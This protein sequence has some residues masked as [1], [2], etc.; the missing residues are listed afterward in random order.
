[1]KL[2]NDL[3]PK[4]TKT[5]G[6]K[7]KLGDNDQMWGSE[8]LAALY[9]QHPYLGSYETHLQVEG[10]DENLGYLYGHFIVKNPG[11]T[12]PTQASS[13]H[14]GQ[15]QKEV[16]PGAPEVRIPVVVNSGDLSALDVFISPSNAFMPL[17][18]DRLAAS[19]FQE[20]NFVPV[21][22]SQASPHPSAAV[23][24]N[25]VPNNGLGGV[26]DHSATVKRASVIEKVASYMSKEARAAIVSDLEEVS[27][28]RYALARNKNFANAM[29]KFASTPKFVAS[30]VDVDSVDAAVVEKVAGGYKL[31]V[32]S[33]S[34]FEPVS[35]TVPNNAS[36]S[37]PWSTRAD[38]VKLGAALLSTDNNPAREVSTTEGRLTEVTESGV[39]A[40]MEKTGRATRGVVLTN[41]Q[42]LEGRP[43]DLKLAITPEGASLQDK[44]AGVRCGDIDVSRIEGKPPKGDGVFLLKSGAVTEPLTINNTINYPDRKEYTYTS[45]MG[46]SGVLKTASVA[47]P[48]NV[49]GADYLI[50]E[51]IKF[52]P[53]KYSN[54]V[55]GDV[56]SVEKLASDVELS[57]KVTVVADGGL[58]S[59]RGGSGVSELPYQDINQVKYASALLMMGLLGVGPDSAK[60]KLAEARDGAAVEFVPSRELAVKVK[61]ASG[62][63]KEDI[64]LI[65]SL[66]VDL[67]KEASAVAMPQETVDAVL[68]LGFVN[69]QNIQ[70]YLASL[71][72][73]ETCLSKLCEML[74]GVRLGL[75]DIPENAVENCVKGVTKVLDGLKQLAMRSQTMEQ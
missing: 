48:L 57:R 52:I 31:T 46:V 22:K 24:M 13:G 58:F 32:A 69:P 3:T 44:V 4:F 63:S 15:V 30:Q 50:P 23:D 17:N 14:V 9:K 39:Y 18:E 6:K 11:T 66:R 5:A 21:N 53:L 43:T 34:A 65:L 68:S 12:N 64:D 38:A 29:Y 49:E 75:P 61:T 10:H 20:N 71:P 26:Q 35:I 72:E 40:V 56:V 59:F 1:M 62:M 54:G 45:A 2:F 67:T 55:R 25:Q 33:A 28:V 51:D 16:A 73:L 70:G 36:E 27:W 19:L 41:I 37:I 74:I 42:T 7:T 47:K 60:V 8:I